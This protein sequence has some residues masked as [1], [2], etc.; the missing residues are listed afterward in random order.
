LSVCRASMRASRA[1]Y[2]LQYQSSLVLN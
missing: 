2:W 1:S